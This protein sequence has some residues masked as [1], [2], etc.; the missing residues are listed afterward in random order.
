LEQL[1]VAT[2]EYR[3]TGAIAAVLFID[4]DKFK[5]INDEKGHDVGDAVLCTVAQRLQNLVRQGDTVARLGGDEFVL[6]L[7]EL[8]QS[9][10]LAEAR[11]LAVAEQVRAALSD[12]VTVN[13]Q[14]YF[15]GGSIGVALVDSRRK[16][17]NDILREADTAMYKSKD[18]GRNRVALFRP[19]MLADV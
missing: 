5:N 19:T 15:T 12:T 8:G 11:A 14:A 6:L 18:A 16:K 13:G 3:N 7:R 4:L 9:R 1:E 2:L 17:P 10:E